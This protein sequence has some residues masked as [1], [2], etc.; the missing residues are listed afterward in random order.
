MRAGWKMVPFEDAVDDVS[1]GNPKIPQSEFLEAG[2]Y[3]VVDQGKELVAGFTNDKALLCRA[4]GPV[5]VFGDH[6]CCFKYVD[7]PFAMG[8][9]GVKVLRPKVEMKVKYL[10]HYLSQ[11]RLPES[12]YAR[13]FKHLKRIEVAVPP[14]DEQVRI[15]AVLDRAVALRRKRRDALEATSQLPSSVFVEMF[16]DPIFNPKR[17]PEKKLR[18]LG[19]LDRGVSKH[20]PRNAP[21][22]L[23]GPYPL[24]QTGEVAN[25]AGYIRGFTATYSEDGLRQSKM[26][27]AGTL[28]I[29]IA[30]NIAKTG[31]LTFD[32]CFPDSVVGF[33]TE[34]EATVLF[35]QTW[36][37][38][39]QKTLEET[40]PEVAQKN[41]NLAI[42]R[43]LEVPVPPLELQ[44]AFA[45]KVKAVEAMRVKLR[46]SVEL[47]DELFAAL[48]S[49]AFVGAL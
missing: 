19:T 4:E 33:Q 29:T 2:R 5:I 12:G 49:R 3:A 14:P 31:I 1:G 27:P 25:S 21:H 40:A 41:I 9:D 18:D 6:T 20:R 28:C 39:L 42:L 45:A 8:A 22:L 30:A 10:H 47:M 23:G 24:I 11:V 48:Q 36:L 13:N 34:E 46:R 43:E 44:R 15:V 38:F 35:V 17:W 7:F 16:G 32:A 26:W 37:S